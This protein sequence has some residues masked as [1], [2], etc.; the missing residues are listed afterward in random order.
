MRGI[1]CTP[2]GQELRMVGIVTGSKTYNVA[3]HAL[4]GGRRGYLE[5]SALHRQYTPTIRRAGACT[6]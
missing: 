3:I 5:L 6:T 4:R 1:N 2:H